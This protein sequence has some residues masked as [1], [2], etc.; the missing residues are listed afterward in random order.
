MNHEDLWHPHLKRKWISEKESR[1]EDH[2][3]K[4]F[5]TNLSLIQLNQPESGDITGET[6]IK[7]L[8]NNPKLACKCSFIK[9]EGCK[10]NPTSK[11]ASAKPISLIQNNLKEENIESVIGN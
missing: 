2:K 8:L 5:D 11:I 6:D 7:A 9:D 1:I 3:N 10:S 4:F